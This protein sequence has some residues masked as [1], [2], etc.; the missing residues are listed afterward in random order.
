[1]SYFVL[2]FA[3]VLR[4][5]VNQQVAVLSGYGH[6][7]MPLEVKLI[8]TA[9][10]ELSLQAVWRFAQRFLAVPPGERLARQDE[11]LLANSFLRIEYRG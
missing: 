3:R 4:R 5:A 2:N 7:D 10:V 8:L 6:G 9:Q 11:G 1:M